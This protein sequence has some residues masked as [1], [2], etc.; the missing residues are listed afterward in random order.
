[1]ASEKDGFF[2]R[3]LKWIDRDLVLKHTLRHPILAMLGAVLA[4]AVAVFMMLGIGTEFLPPFNEGSVTINVLM[5]PGTSLQESS[6]I[7]RL[8]EGL[9][10]Q[11]P[12]TQSPET[13]GGERL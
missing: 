5:P 11:V 13:R 6:R 7:G 4:L 9:I 2:V 12:E 8:A 10:L 3:F 1:M